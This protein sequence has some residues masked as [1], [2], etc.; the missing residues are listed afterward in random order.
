LVAGGASRAR[1][2]GVLPLPAL[3]IAIAAYVSLVNLGGPF[4]HFQWDALLIETGAAS[5]QS[6]PLV[7]WHRSGAAREPPR[8]A[9]SVLYLLLFKLMFLSGWVKLASGDPTWKSL[10]ALVY[11]Y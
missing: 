4:T 8:L 5:L 2:I 1:G 7:L 11:H 9:R 3:L 6:L 10:A